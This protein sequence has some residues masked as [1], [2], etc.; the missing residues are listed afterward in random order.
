MADIARKPHALTQTRRN[1]RP[2][3][4]VFFDTETSQVTRASGEVHHKLRLG[5]AVKARRRRGEALRLQ[6]EHDFYS[7]DDFFDWLDDQ[8]PPKSK[9]YL[10]AHNLNFDL[11][12]LHAFKQLAHRG[13]KLDS[14]YTAGMVGIFRWS[15][16]KRNIIALD[17]GNFFGGK[18]EEWGKVVGRL[19]PQVDFATVSNLELMHRCREDTLI[20]VELWR[21]WIAFLDANDC[22][23]FKPTVAS[24]AFNTWRR[25]FMPADVWVHCNPLATELERE[26][27]HGGRV[28]CLWIG[29]REDGPFYYLDVNS[30]YAY[31]MSL[32]EF[33]AGLL[34]T[35][36]KGTIETL[37]R[38]I[39]K[40]SVISRVTLDTT[41]NPYPFKAGDVTSYPLGRFDATL[42]TEELRMALDRGWISEVGA[43]AWY[44]KAMLFHD[45]A[46]YF[47]N[48]R[49]EYKRAGQ[50]G[51]QKIAKLLING[52][53]GKFGQ[54]G[55]SQKVIGSCD[56]SKVGV[57]KVRDVVHNTYYELVYLGGQVFRV[58]H[59]GEAWNSIPGVAAHVTAGARMYLHSLVKRV[60]P[61]HVFY[62]DTDSL[63]VDVIGLS[64]LSRLLH[65]DMLGC[66]KVERESEWLEINAP[67]DY[68]M[69]AVTKRKGIRAA[70]IEIA[71]GVFKQEQWPRLPGMLRNGELED[72]TVTPHQKRLSRTLRAGVVGLDGWVA[73][74]RLAPPG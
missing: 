20:M 32:G 13:W 28:E 31:I 21:V 39:Q 41:D 61:G 16:K 48:I 43:M 65:P 37:T 24:T 71:P 22:G 46:E 29:R 70:A 64:E 44:R 18:L 72:Y 38:R 73:P 36:P 34:G 11:P 56:P 4:V 35:T 30:M 40:Y 27:Y 53:Y 57:E 60:T 9:C 23:E 45:Y 66:L 51:Y 59:E 26:S 1:F 68:A 52:L 5:Y 14:F 19:K 10:V 7:P 67:K 50:D 58:E 2:S 62:M 74:P 15:N 42:T 25:R 54:R 33:P 6:A 55:I 69:E 3:L 63:I 8:I 49:L 47:Y 17:N 12:V